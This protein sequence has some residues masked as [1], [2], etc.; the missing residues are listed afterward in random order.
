MHRGRLRAAS[1]TRVIALKL[2][3]EVGAHQE[4]A[5]APLA[6]KVGALLSSELTQQEL[7]TVMLCKKTGR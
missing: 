7:V 6:V 1:A 3:E 5:I 2:E 4:R